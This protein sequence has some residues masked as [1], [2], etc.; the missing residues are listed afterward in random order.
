MYLKRRLKYCIHRD[1]TALVLDATSAVIFNIQLCNCH[2]L[3]VPYMVSYFY[4]MILFRN[5]TQDMG[6][7]VHIIIMEP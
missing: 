3:G 6:H 1:K 2:M 4:T 7:P 5:W